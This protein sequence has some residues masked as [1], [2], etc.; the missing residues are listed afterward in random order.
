M[1][2]PCGPLWISGGRDVVDAVSWIPLDGILHKGELD[3][4]LKPLDAY[5]AGRLTQFPGGLFF[6]GPGSLWLRK[7]QGTRPLIGSQGVLVAISKIPYGST[8]TYG[9]IAAQ[10]LKP[11]AARAVGAVCRANTLPVIIPC[12]RVVGQNSM[13][14]YTPDTQLKEYLLTLEG[15][16]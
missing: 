9:E 13:G 11:G 5:F 2:T 8:R 16:S 1:A 4:V 7:P 10:A 14:G 6:M 15:A 12:H 3:W